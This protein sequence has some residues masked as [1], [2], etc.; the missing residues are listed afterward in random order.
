MRE[1]RGYADRCA[2]RGEGER[3]EHRTCFEVHA[4][5][6]CVGGHHTCG[7]TERKSEI[8]T[9][10]RPKRGREEETKEREVTLLGGFSCRLSA[11]T[12][13]VTPSSSRRPSPSSSLLT[14]SS[15][16]PSS[17]SFSVSLTCCRRAFLSIRDFCPSRESNRRDT[18]PIT[19][20]RILFVRWISGVDCPAEARS[21]I[22][23]RATRL[24][25]KVEKKEEQEEEESRCT[26][27]IEFVERVTK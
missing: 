2:R 3:K 24:V 4:R 26:R 9:H 11:T 22:V 6:S 16:T 23:E 5:H 18:R 1:H 20:Q 21:S 15:C 10:T 8:H 27:W 17:C 13:G 12:R 19:L 7:D 14:A 25:N